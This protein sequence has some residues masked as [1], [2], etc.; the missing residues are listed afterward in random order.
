MGF[1]DFASSITSAIDD[2]KNT[3]GSL[4]GLPGANSFSPPTSGPAFPWKTSQVES[5]FFPYLKIDGTRW[6]S[7]YP[8]RFVVVDVNN[9]NQTVGDA[10]LSVSFSQG[11]SG[12]IVAFSSLSSAWIF[13]LPISP[14]QLNIQDMFAINTSATLSGIVEEHNGVRFKMINAAGTMGVWSNRTSVVKP[15]TTPNPVASLF[16]GTITAAQNVL[17]QVGGLINTIATGHSGSGPK[18]T[19]PEAADGGLAAT[20]Y[21]QALGLQQFLEQYAEAKKNPKNAG[22]RLVLDIP[23]QNQSFVVTPMQFTWQQNINK[24]TEILYNM[25]LKAWRRIDLKE[26]SP[27]AQPASI[28][29]VGPGLLAQILNSI[30][31][32]REVASS[33]TNLIGAVRS[34]VE[35]PLEALR[36]TALLVK[37]LAGVA[38][39]VADLPN[40]IIKDYSSSIKASIALLS[41]LNGGVNNN[42]SDSTTTSAIAGIKASMLSYEGLPDS[43][44]SSGQLGN[45]VS[46]SLAI[47]PAN[48]VF[49]NPSSSFTLFDQVDVTALS[50]T[51]AQ[52]NTVS[53]IVNNARQITVSDLK[54]FRATILQL[55]LQ[56]SNNFGAGDTFYSE[57]YGT[58]T[59]TARIQPITLDE[60]DILK[61]FYDVISAYDSLTATLDIDFLNKQTNMDYVA[62]LAQQSNILFDSSTA[63]LLAPVPFGLTIEAI[64]ARYL[65]DPQRWLE[66]VTLNNLR[67]PYIDEDGFQLPL[68]SNATGRQVTI[69]SISN[70]YIGQRVL[71][72]SSTQ[73]PTARQI[74]NIETLSATSHL[75]TL[76]GL[77]NLG[78]YVTV[79]KAS[80]QAYLPGTVNSQQKIFI[81]TNLPISDDPNIVMPALASA[82]PLS[83]MS[84]VD[85]LLTDTGDIAI[86]NF[87]DFRISYGLTN[88]I[89]ALKIKL[90]TVP[91]TVLLHPEFGFGFRPG[92]IV[93]D[94]DFPQVFKTLNA[95]LQQDPRFEGLANLEI[96]INGPVLSINMGVQL[97]GRQ[98]IFPINFNLTA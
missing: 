42:P 34:D 63:K 9:G 36:Q 97:A 98:G 73:S 26:K 50:L 55:S 20:G 70:L 13:Q 38:V 85:L 88:I 7:L 15:P 90:S 84:K 4:L 67:D 87:G 68:L 5:S 43:A 35:A 59:P 46:N 29:K 21:Y 74:L 53:N 8:Y 49:I 93:S 60:Y 32:A 71:V 89:Q 51:P 37:D 58:P 78:N 28:N 80:L 56:L 65:G 18:T 64:A 48:N 17:G 33:I 25:Q 16:G 39:T 69:A 1:G 27:I 22:W 12:A 47:D 3:L 79:D 30:H 95:V 57:V 44:V 54:A 96:Q 83:S 76:D 62:G 31:Q 52:Q 77:A 91:R 19:R 72:Q 10:D 40:Q 11:T 75:I 94:V 82:D 23:K 45:G 66:I 61:S 6:D 92:T 41:N 14:Q 86:N 24:P 2:A 81:P